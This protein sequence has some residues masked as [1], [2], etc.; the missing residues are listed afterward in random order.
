[1]KLLSSSILIHPFGP[2]YTY[3]VQ[4]WRLFFSYDYTVAGEKMFFKK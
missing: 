3:I 1:M 2:H 4:D